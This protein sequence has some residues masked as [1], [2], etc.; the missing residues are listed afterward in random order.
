MIY[1]IIAKLE[2]HFEYEDE[3]QYIFSYHVSFLH[4]F[5]FVIFCEMKGASKIN[6]RKSRAHFIRELKAKNIE[7]EKYHKKYI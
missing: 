6:S 7:V 5:I 4:N 3:K 2:C 1:W